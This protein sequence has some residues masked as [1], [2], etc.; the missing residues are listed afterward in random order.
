MDGFYIKSLLFVATE[1]DI[2]QD[3]GQR[4]HCQVPNEKVLTAKLPQHSSKSQ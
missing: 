1:C 2:E 3:N 4:G